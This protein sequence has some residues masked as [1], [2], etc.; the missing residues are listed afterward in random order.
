MKKVGPSIARIRSINFTIEVVASCFTQTIVEVFWRTV[1]SR[2]E[3]V[4]MKE[5]WITIYKENLFRFFF[6]PGI[7]G[8]L[9]MKCDLDLP[10]QCLPTKTT[11]ADSGRWGVGWRRSTVREVLHFYNLTHIFLSQQ[12]SPFSADFDLAFAVFFKKS[13]KYTF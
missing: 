2:R 6:Y 10:N 5:N 11:G 4:N 13:P 8:C 1:L 9:E 12:K 3:N 7:E